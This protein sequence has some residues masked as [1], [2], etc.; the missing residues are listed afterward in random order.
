LTEV[1]EGSK[2]RAEVKPSDLTFPY[3]E[4]P[5]PQT[6]QSALGAAVP[7]LVAGELLPPIRSWRNATLLA[8]MR[9]PVAAFY[10][11]HRTR[12]SDDNIGPARKRPNV[13]S[14]THA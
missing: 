13:K 4:N 3:N 12:P 7:S 6:A 1:E 8:A 5:P 11:N 14:V 10:L 2:S 9:V